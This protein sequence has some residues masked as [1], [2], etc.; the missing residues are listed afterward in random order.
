MLH[1]TIALSLL[2]LMGGT[3]LLR[4]VKTDA[5]GGFARFVALLV[6]VMSFVMLIFDISHGVMGMH[7][8]HEGY[9]I[10]GGMGMHDGRG[11]MCCCDHNMHG[12]MKC[13]DEKGGMAGCR[14]EMDEHEDKT[15]D[16]SGSSRR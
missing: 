10:H 11:G 16:S 7:G 12:G 13:C 6:I 15:Q 14:E 2:T 5:M 8:G 3:L 4:K 1:V 9:G